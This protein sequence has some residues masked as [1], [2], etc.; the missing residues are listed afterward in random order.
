MVVTV[1]DCDKPEEG[2]TEVV[3][4]KIADAQSIRE[5]WKNKDWA[6][7]VCRRIA[8]SVKEENDDDELDMDLYLNKHCIKVPDFPMIPILGDCRLIPSFFANSKPDRGQHQR[9]SFEW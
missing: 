7:A 1:F 5:N 8:S 3:L 2:G 9:C 4:T 6:A